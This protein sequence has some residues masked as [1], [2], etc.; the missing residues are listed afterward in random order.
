MIEEFDLEGRP[1]AGL[2]K[3][4]LSFM[5]VEQIMDRLGI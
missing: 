5:A 2:P 4:S 3:D 1:L